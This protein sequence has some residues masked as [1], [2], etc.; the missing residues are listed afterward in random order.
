[1]IKDV[2]TFTQKKRLQ[3]P[4]FIIWMYKSLDSLN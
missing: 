2:V 3:E 4:M 1:M